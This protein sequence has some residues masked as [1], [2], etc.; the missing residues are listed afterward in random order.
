MH[1]G[2]RDTPDDPDEVDRPDDLE[3]P[4]GDRPDDDRPDHDRPDDDPEPGDVGDGHAGPVARV[5][6]GVQRA[7]RTDATAFGYSI[8]ATATFGVAQ[9]GAPPVTL[10]RIVAF[11]IGASLGFTL[12][13]FA[14]TRGFRV[15]IHAE[16]SDVVLV[17]TALAPVSVGLGLLAAVGL[18]TV[19]RAGWAWPLAP[20]AATAVYVLAAGIVG[21]RWAEEHPPDEDE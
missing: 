6:H 15:R 16:R 18:V 11:A 1:D 19:V 21:R 20:L 12:W 7:V 13:E 4:D 2:D 9:V 17:G 10:P 8:L 3:P 14:A 5:G